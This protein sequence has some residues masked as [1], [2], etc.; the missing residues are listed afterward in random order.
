MDSTIYAT[1][2]DA[3]KAGSSSGSVKQHTSRKGA[4]PLS[5]NMYDFPAGGAL[6][7]KPISVLSRP[8]NPWNQKNVENLDAKFEDEK[9]A[10]QNKR[11]VYSNLCEKSYHHFRKPEDYPTLWEQ[12]HIVDRGRGKVAEVENKGVYDPL[13][14]EYK[15]APVVEEQK[16][17]SRPSDNVRSNSYAEVYAGRT[18]PTQLEGK[19]TQ[20]AQGRYNP[21]THSYVDSPDPELADRREKEFRRSYGHSSGPAPRRPLTAGPKDTTDIISNTSTR[22]STASVRT[23][24]QS[25]ETWGTYNPLLHEWKVPPRDTRYQN[26]EA[27]VTRRSGITGQKP[28]G[29]NAMQ[30][31]YNPITN[32]WNVLPSN[33]RVV[34]GLSFAPATLFTRLHPATIRM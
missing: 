11:E 34:D 33:P 19:R 23:S 27:V 9:K 15:I 29:A 5:Q 12:G 4:L 16:G 20:S 13:Q 2:V 30:G 32:T 31:S 7:K 1:Y 21:V 18:I 6:S 14:H 25:G 22:P 10:Y 24:V 3:Y 26:T 28:R 8:A 17:F